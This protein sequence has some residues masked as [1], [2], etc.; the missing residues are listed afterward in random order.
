ML[1]HHFALA[2]DHARAHRY[3]MAAA[4][5]ATE[6][7]SHA[8]AVR[9]YQRAI[10]AGR[11]S[12]V[13]VDA[14]A[15]AGAWEQMGDALRCVGEPA[16]ATRALTQARRLLRDEPL[17]QARLCHRHAEVAER[18]D[19]LIGAVRWL[20]R[21]LR[22]LNGLGTREAIA[23]RAR[24]RAYLGGI[25]N[26]QGRFGDAIAACREAI[27]EAESVGELSALAHASYALDWALVESGRRAEATHSA[28]ALDIY[29]RLGDPEHEMIVLNNLGMFAY[30]EGRWD[31]AVDLYRRAGDCGERAGRPADAAFTD[32]NVGEILSDQG[33]LNEAEAYLQRARRVWSA[34]GERQAVAFVDVLLARLAVRR[35]DCARAVPLLEAAEVELRRF[36]VHA[37]AD[38]SH[39]LV[40]EAEALAGNPAR[41]LELGREALLTADRQRPLL[42]RALG[43]ALA[44]LGQADAARA[45]LVSA[46][47]TARE[48]GAEY[49]LAA[50]MDALDALGA[51]GAEA[52]QERDQILA[53]LKIAKLAR[54]APV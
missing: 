2:G 42:Q 21:G 28:L 1:S 53:R 3:A 13:A 14:H 25:R 44:R 8:D 18:S 15:L 52:R 4:E 7:F 38:F 26:R 36:R 51:A 37:Y 24:M 6:R 27:A 39:A 40:V 29:E 41:A 19:A 43:V 47:A 12:D 20:G 45:E 31:D 32:C 5:R 9:L 49:D 17:I 54:P 35:G 46:I 16:A 10:D 48:R 33:H 23:R 50:A 34:T 30:F 11:T 22:A